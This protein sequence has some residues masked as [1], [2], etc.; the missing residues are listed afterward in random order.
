MH[1]NVST[2]ELGSGGPSNLFKH[3]RADVKM[4]MMIMKCVKN[5]IFALLLQTYVLQDIDNSI[6]KANHSGEAICYINMGRTD[7]EGY[8][9]LPLQN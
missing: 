4:M 9:T 2:G 5:N 7:S 1:R 3:G 6:N 8:K